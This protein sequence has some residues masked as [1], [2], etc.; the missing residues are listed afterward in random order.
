MRIEHLDA[1]P[2]MHT[3]RHCH[4]CHRQAQWRVD[5]GSLRPELKLCDRCGGY[6]SRV[7]ADRIA[8]VKAG[9]RKVGP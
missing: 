2:W 8:E 6:L 3:P 7:L 5:F 9:Q 4:G 1:S